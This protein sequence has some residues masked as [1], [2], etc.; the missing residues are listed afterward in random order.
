[1]P[2]VRHLKET[3]AIPVCGPCLSI[4]KEVWWI[5]GI[6]PRVGFVKKIEND[7]V[8]VDDGNTLVRLKPQEAILLTTPQD[9]A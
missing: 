3:E 6:I 4:D 8:V 1:M 7:A 5:Q 2:R 9:K